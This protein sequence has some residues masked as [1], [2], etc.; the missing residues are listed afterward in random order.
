MHAVFRS[1]ALCGGIRVTGPYPPRPHAAGCAA[2][3]T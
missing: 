3:G 1:G 2:R